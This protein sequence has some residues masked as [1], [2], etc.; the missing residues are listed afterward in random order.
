MSTVP[1]FKTHSVP[2]S[3]CWIERGEGK[4]QGC[5]LET[6]VGNKGSV[7]NAPCDLGQVTEPQFSSTPIVREG[8]MKQC[9]QSTQLWPQ[10]TGSSFHWHSGQNGCAR[11]SWLGNALT[12]NFWPDCESN[13]VYALELYKVNLLMISSPDTSNLWETG[14]S[15]R[16]LPISFIQY[17][18]VSSSILKISKNV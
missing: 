5:E 2:R 14:K 15:F 17:L 16:C 10:H 1:E 6:L 7:L 12:S 8:R 4:S 18:N 3:C 13:R 9:R 11:T